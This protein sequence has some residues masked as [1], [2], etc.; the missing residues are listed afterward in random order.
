MRRCGPGGG[1]AFLPKPF[2]LVARKESIA[3]IKG[4]FDGLAKYLD[5]L[6]DMFLFQGVEKYAKH[7]EISGDLV[8]FFGAGLLIAYLVAAMN[9]IPGYEPV[10]E[11]QSGKSAAEQ[12]SQPPKS[13]DSGKDPVSSSDMAQFAILSILGGLAAHGFLILYSKAFKTPIGSVKETLNAVFAYN[14][15]YHPFDALSEHVRRG[16]KAIP[17]ATKGAFIVAG[18]MLLIVGLSRF[19]SS[20]YLIY[21]MAALHH[22]T[23]G[24]M[25]WINIVFVLSFFAVFFAFFQALGVSPR[26]VLS[27]ALD[28]KTNPS[29][30]GSD[31]Q[32]RNVAE[33]NGRNTLEV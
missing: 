11:T 10:P 14:A 17:V 2:C 27:Q 25:L 20:V 22:T 13:E 7:G 33:V 4:L 19:L 24:Q 23:F 8:A 32:E 26:T 15:L 12:S 3:D 31:K 16:A 21:A 5:F 29:L 6:V 30:T 1:R 9:K 18:L 28:A